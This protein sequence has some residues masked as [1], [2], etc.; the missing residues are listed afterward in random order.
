[1][2]TGKS[3]LFI[4]PVRSG[5]M[6]ED[7]VTCMQSSDV[8]EGDGY[9]V[10]EI[11]LLSSDMTTAK[12]NTTA[13]DGVIIDSAAISRGGAI[14]RG[15]VITSPHTRVQECRDDHDLGMMEV[16]K[17][18]TEYSL[19]QSWVKPAPQSPPGWVALKNPTAQLPNNLTWMDTGGDGS[20][21]V[22][23]LPGNPVLGRGISVLGNHGSRPSSLQ[24]VGE[25]SKVSI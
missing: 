25:H 8:I 14:M 22:P 16:I 19:G 9:S 2:I 24:H 13:R 17:R 23:C 5:A 12:D 6:L 1:M 15:G 7:T 4:P 18:E 10:R 3:I 11:T 21:G 20:M